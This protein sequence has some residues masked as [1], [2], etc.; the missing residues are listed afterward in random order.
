MKLALKGT[1][2]EVVSWPENTASICR[3]HVVVCSMLSPWFL[4]Q[5]AIIMINTTDCCLN[6]FYNRMLSPWFLQQNTN[7]MISSTECCHSWYN[8]M[9]SLWLT[10]QNVITMIDTTDWY[11]HDWHNRM[12]SSW[13]IEQN[14]ITMTDTT[15]RYHHDCYNRKVCCEFELLRVQQCW[16]VQ[17]QWRADKAA[18]LH[19]D[20]LAVMLAL[21]ITS[22]THTDRHKMAA[23]MAMAS[24]LSNLGQK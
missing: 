12:I 14:A 10:Q 20:C 16:F 15:E 17:Y 2:S 9:L 23:L 22:Q 11:H 5:N 7:T 19:N 21:F 24:P 6:D 18:L 1:P 13:L 3:L 4:Q 8:R